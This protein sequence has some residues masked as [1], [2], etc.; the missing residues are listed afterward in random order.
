MSPVLGGL[1]GK[2]TKTDC[3]K[4]KKKR[5]KRNRKEKAITGR[6]KK[7]GSPWEGGGQKKDLVLLEVES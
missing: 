7:E 1:Q 3:H 4:R 5:E 6:R 2:T